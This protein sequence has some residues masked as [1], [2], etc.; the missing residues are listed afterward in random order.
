LKVSNH[1]VT[2]KF[3]H[4]AIYSQLNQHEKALEMCKSTFPLLSKAVDIIETYCRSQEEALIAQSGEEGVMFSKKVYG[5]ARP[6]LS[7]LM[8]QLADSVC[9]KQ[10]KSSHFYFW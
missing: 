6:I 2:L 4:C 3:Q 7:S 1:L 10:S 8:T 5:F 9:P